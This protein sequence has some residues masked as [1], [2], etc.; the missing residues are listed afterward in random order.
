VAVARG[1]A[2]HCLALAL[3]GRSIFQTV[4]TERIAI[5]TR[6][7]W[8]E[9]LPRGATLPFPIPGGWAENTQLQVPEGVGHGA[10]PL[11]AEFGVDEPGA[12]RSLFAEPWPLPRSAK[13]GNALRL[14][15]RIN[16]N[17]IFRF[18]LALA[19]DVDALPFEGYIK[20]PLSNV[21]T[22]GPF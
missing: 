20:N 13:R 15:Y 16:E 7:G 22:R 10:A 19:A 6:S 9:L 12:E 2:Y 21:L 1:A 3:Y 4:A 17:Q 8:R 5:R 14:S 11:R 18:Q